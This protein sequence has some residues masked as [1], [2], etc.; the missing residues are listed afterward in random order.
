MKSPRRKLD[1]TRGKAIAL[2]IA[3]GTLLA[4]LIAVPAAAQIR[5]V[6]APPAK[7]ESP[8]NS[9]LPEVDV[10]SGDEASDSD[11]PAVAGPVPAPNLPSPA[12]A[13]L[14]DEPQSGEPSRLDPEQVADADPLTLDGDPGDPGERS[15]A[16][17]SRSGERS[18]G[19]AVRLAPGAGEA[20]SSLPPIVDASSRPRVAAGPKPTVIHLT[21]GRVQA[22]S[23]VAQVQTDDGP[24]GSSSAEEGIVIAEPEESPEQAQLC[25]DIDRCL[26]RYSVLYENAATRSPWGM[27]HA[28]LPWGVDAQVIVGN[29]RVNSIGYLCWNG[30]CRKQKLFYQKNGEMALYVGPGVQGHAGQFLAMLAQCRVDRNYEIRIDDRRYTI[31]DLIEYEKATCIPKSELTFKLIGFSHYLDDGE[32]WSNRYGRWN[33]ERVLAEELAQPVVGSACGGTHRLMGISYAINARKAHGQPLNGHFGRAVTFIDDFQQYAL[34]LQNPDGSFSTDW[35]ERRAN[36]PD[37]DRKVQ[38]TG[39]ILEWLVYSLPQERLSD[40]KVVRSVRFI[41]DALNENPDYEFE[42]GPKGHA[43]RSLVLYQRFVFDG[44]WGQGMVEPAALA[45]EPEATAPSTADIR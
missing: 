19:G 43:L 24:G 5:I 36:A 41:V 20:S 34:A 27:M 10:P 22:P 40:P 35:F 4:L 8:K 2:T 12:P 21:D 15:G 6:E 42:V 28:F 30:Q 44:T 7:E 18:A 26:K 32:T 9:D 38:T 14:S 45:A 37:F 33:L 23:G 25:R 16:A 31:R 29:Q 1:E 3:A 17:G 39:H 11:G 13:R